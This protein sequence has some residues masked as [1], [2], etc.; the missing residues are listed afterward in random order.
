MICKN[1]FLIFLRPYPPSKLECSV[2]E[3]YLRHSNLEW[4]VQEKGVKMNELEKYFLKIIRPYS[5]EP[6]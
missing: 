4:L 2:Q 1:K 6:E 5:L 3:N